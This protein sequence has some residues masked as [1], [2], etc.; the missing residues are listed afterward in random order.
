MK[1]LLIV[2]TFIWKRYVKNSCVDFESYVER[3]VMY[4][5]ITKDTKE[6]YMEEV[7]Q[8]LIEKKYSTIM[9]RV[10]FNVLHA[11]KREEQSVFENGVTVEIVDQTSCVLD[12]IKNTAL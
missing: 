5:I 1:D 3:K 6:K 11:T 2:K 4:D 12:A 7:K 8:I 10:E 9:D